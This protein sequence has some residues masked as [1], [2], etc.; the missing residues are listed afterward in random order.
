MYVFCVAI[1]AF[2][3]AN[4]MFDAAVINQDAHQLIRLRYLRLRINIV[5]YLKILPQNFTDERRKTIPRTTNNAS[6]YQGLS[7]RANNEQKT[8]FARVATP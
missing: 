7:I 6:I 1:T 8:K 3:H 2:F 5:Y 4:I